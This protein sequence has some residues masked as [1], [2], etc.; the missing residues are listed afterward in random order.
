M[1][2][3]VNLGGTGNS[4]C[5]NELDMYRLGDDFFININ[6]KIVIYFNSLGSIKGI[7]FNNV[8]II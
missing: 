6:L 2:W 8:N 1:D 5:S 7:K 3:I 4:I